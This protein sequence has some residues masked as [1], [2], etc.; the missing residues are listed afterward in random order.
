[1][2][3]KVE[4]KA[5]TGVIKRPAVGDGQDTGMAKSRVIPL[6]LPIIQPEPVVST[7]KAVLDTDFHRSVIEKVTGIQNVMR[8]SSYSDTDGYPSATRAYWSDIPK[9]LGNLS[10]INVLES[11]RQALEDARLVFRETAHVLAAELGLRNSPHE[12]VGAFKERTSFV[13]KFYNANR[14]L[15]RLAVG[16]L[17]K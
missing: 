4:R 3:E 12:M 8:A 13:R 16:N 6:P 15:H 10:Q 9:L 14:S 5:K 7:P 2:V 17:N 1:M 11:S